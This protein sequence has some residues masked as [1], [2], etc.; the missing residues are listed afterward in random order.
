MREILFRGK[1]HDNGAWVEGDLYVEHFPGTD[2]IHEWL[3]C[4]IRASEKWRPWQ[5]NIFDVDPETVGQYTGLK[6][7]ND[8]KVFEGDVVKMHYFFENYA[9]GT[10]GVFEDEDVLDVVI[11]IDKFGV[12]FEALNRELSGYLCDYLQDPEAELEVIGNIYDNPGLLR[13]IKGGQSD[14][15]ADRK[16]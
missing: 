10:L 7:Q 14:G 6:D 8:K 12:F 16:K 4:S 11:K 9:P 1:R 15:A 2:E 5:G 13:E 3:R